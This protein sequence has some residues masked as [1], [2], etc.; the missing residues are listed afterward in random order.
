MSGNRTEQGL[1]ALKSYRVVYHKEQV[2]LVVQVPVCQGGHE[3]LSH[4]R[5][6]G[7]TLRI[8]KLCTR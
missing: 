7:F 8:A 5:V 6:L 2:E 3:V 1:S 4:S